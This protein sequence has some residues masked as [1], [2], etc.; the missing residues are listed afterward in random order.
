MAATDMHWTYLLNSACRHRKRA[1]KNG[2]MP[3]GMQLK[4]EGL[5][6]E[7]G[8]MKKPRYGKSINSNW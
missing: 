4:L 6:F 2:K 3:L 8:A 7:A 1:Y 5:G